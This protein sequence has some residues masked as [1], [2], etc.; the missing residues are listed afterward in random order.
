MACAIKSNM[1]KL[2]KIFSPKD[3]ATIYF[4]LIHSRLS[5]ALRIEGSTYKTYLQ[6]SVTYQNKSIRIKWEQT[7]VTAQDLSIKT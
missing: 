7:N 3:F 6:K 1:L 5:Y 2:E 4:A